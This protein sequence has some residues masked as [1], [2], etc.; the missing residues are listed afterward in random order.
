MKTKDPEKYAKILAAAK[1]LILRDGA[2]AISTTK[3]AKAVGMAQSNIYI[4][5][6]N[7]DDL[8]QQVYTN[9]QEEVQA[10]FARNIT[11]GADLNV[12]V[13]E[14]IDAM[15]QFASTN[16]ATFELL[17]QIKALPDADW[18][19]TVTDAQAPVKMIQAAID[20]QVLR[21]VTPAIIMTVV[22][23]AI[24]HYVI[25]TQRGDTTDFNEVRT[26]LLQGIML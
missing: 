24:R 3:V 16:F 4:Y 12:A 22:Y 17:H 5:F 11:Q 10:S 26:L 2:A 9:A 23:N 21:P 14:Y 20:A 1:D 18:T 13:R 25:G 15:Y 7:K 6:K 8:L 19:R